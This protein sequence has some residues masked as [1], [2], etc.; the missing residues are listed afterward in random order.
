MLVTIISLTTLFMILAIVYAFL[1]YHTLHTKK[2]IMAQLK[3]SEDHFHSLVELSPDAIVVH[4]GHEIVFVNEAGLKMVDATDK[5]E[6]L[7]KSIIDYVHPNF[8]EVVKNRIQQMNEGLKAKM[9]EQKIIVPNGAMMDVEITGTK[10]IFE[11]Q[12]AIQLVIKEITEQKRIRREL[13]VNQQQY[14]SLFEHNPDGI[15][16]ID[17]NGKITNVNQALVVLSGYSED[18]LLTMAFHPLIDEE[19]SELATENFKKALNGRPQNFELVG[20]QKDGCRVN[21]NITIMPIIVDSEIIGVYGIAK[22]ISK[23][24]EALLLLEQKEEKYRSLFDHNLDAVFEMDLNGSFKNINKMAEK[25]THFSKKELLTM[26]YHYLIENSLEREYKNFSIVKE[27]QPFHIE[28]KLHDKFGNLIEVDFSAIPIRI[29]GKTNGV[30]AIVRDITEKKHAQK[31]IKE[32]AYTDQLTGLPNRHWFYKELKAIVEQAQKDERPFAILTIDFDNFK[33]VND[34]FGHN[35]GDYLLRQVSNRLRCC[36]RKNDKISRLGGDEF[37][38]IL[39]NITRNDVNQ[40]AKRILNE[41]TPPILIYDQ[42]IIVTLSIGISMYSDCTYDGETLIKQA[43]LAMYLAK[44]SGKNNYQFFTEKLHA[45]ATRKLQI[46]NA[47]STAIEQNEF[48]LF[49]QPQVDLHTRKLIGMEVLLRWN[50][51]FGFVSPSEFIPIAEETGLILPIG[52]W[53]IK[54]ACRQL[55]EWEKQQLPK[56]RVCVNVSARQLKNRDFPLTVKKIIEEENVNPNYLEF[57]ITESIMLN[58]E[59][60][61]QLINELKKLGVKIA[62]DDFGAGYSSLNGIKNVKIDTLK[63]DKSLL[64]NVTQNDRMLSM[65]KAVIG[66]GKTLNAQVIIEGIETKK[67]VELLKEFFVIGQGYFY[68]QPLPPEQLHDVWEEKWKE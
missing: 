42:E 52:E 35:A 33:S 20:L 43:D 40:I 51:S 56:I 65:L 7:G 41:M 10:I 34:T 13:E 27:G 55:K 22:D 24:K 16:S 14:Q 6:L 32:L 47:L 66:V 45:R 59:E 21:L 4:C 68:S 31:R 11:N 5:N 1:Y 30:F 48:T 18:E 37:I 53:V 50:P 67:Q 36:L 46:K 60:A 9:M 61:S 39:D 57:E 3:E 38:I 25:L 15:F 23:E 49:Y 17:H 44:E 26:S 63:I 58:V 2:L 29:Q 62:I 28:Q 8:K 19:Y 54:D 12:P 64:E